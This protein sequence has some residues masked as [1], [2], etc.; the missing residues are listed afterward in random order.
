MKL[1]SPQLL[2]RF[3]ETFDFYRGLILETFEQEVGD[4]PNWP[5]I[6]S[7]VLKCM[8]DRGLEGKLRELLGLPT[9]NIRQS[10]DFPNDREGA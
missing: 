9:K 3:L 4:Q 2:L 7:R 8:G 6:R 1:N 5:L 10:N